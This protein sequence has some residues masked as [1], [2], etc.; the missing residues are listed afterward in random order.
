[1]P[2]A[3]SDPQQPPS[4]GRRRPG[5]TAGPPNVG[6]PV[7][8]PM[9]SQPPSAA[10]TTLLDTTACASGRPFSCAVSSAGLPMSPRVSGGADLAVDLSASGHRRLLVAYLTGGC[11]L[12]RLGN[13]GQ[14][15][16][17]WPTDV[18]WPA[19]VEPP[20]GRGQLGRDRRRDTVFQDLPMR[21]TCG[22]AQARVLRAPRFTAAPAA[23][24]SG[25]P[26]VA[27]GFS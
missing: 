20:C 25:L 19:W 14:A 2:A 9:C 5:W 15:G 18:A 26:R 12:V 23:P 13:S 21:S 11:L 7:P 10:L 27:T 22:A 8:K 17:S 4:S 3:R 6:M 1:M 16:R 24:A